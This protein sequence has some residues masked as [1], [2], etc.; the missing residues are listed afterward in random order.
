[1]SPVG[2]AIALPPGTAERIRA[3]SQAH[4]E[5][6]DPCKCA[7]RRQPDNQ[8]LQNTQTRV[9]LH[10]ADHAQNRLRGHQ[11]IGIQDQ[12][13]IE[14]VTPARHEILDVSRFESGVV[15]AASIAD[16]HVW[17]P[18]L[19]QAPNAGFFGLDTFRPGRVAENE[20]LECL[21]ISRLL[22][23]LDHP[24]EMTH[25]PIRILVADTA[26]NGGLG[27]DGVRWITFE[28]TDSG[29]RV[30]MATHQS[31]ADD[32]VPKADHG[33]GQGQ[34][35][36]QGQ[37]RVEKVEATARQGGDH[38]RDCACSRGDDQKE[39]QGAATRHHR[40]IGFSVVRGVRG[41]TRQHPI[42]HNK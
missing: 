42:L 31:K 11:A 26:E 39:E 25:D 10:D 41:A 1:M 9:A 8:A 27:V 17:R 37:H 38:E 5:L 23:T 34:R 2:S 28:R 29:G 7:R 15:R 22:K 19:A 33:P 18:A 21:S 40:R 35:E 4:S 6:K 16:A 13:E 30:A 32:G 36:A 12:S 20:D 3:H 14:F 24:I